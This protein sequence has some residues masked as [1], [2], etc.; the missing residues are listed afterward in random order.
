MKGCTVANYRL[1]I[2]GLGIRRS[3]CQTPQSSTK[4]RVLLIT[5]QLKL[6]GFVFFL[7]MIVSGYWLFEA[8]TVIKRTVFQFSLFSSF[9][10]DK[11][12]RQRFQKGS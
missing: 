3:T 10:G 4:L 9:D 11:P 6:S 7:L 5:S 12:A 8:L 1:L 2:V